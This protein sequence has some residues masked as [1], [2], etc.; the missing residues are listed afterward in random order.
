MATIKKTTKRTIKKAA[1]G[2]GPGDGFCGENWDR[3]TRR[4]RRRDR[5]IAGER[6]D[7]KLMRGVGLATQEGQEARQTARWDRKDTRKDNREYRRQNTPDWNMGG[8]RGAWKKG[9]KMAKKS[10]MAKLKMKKGGKVKKAQNG[11]L[12]TEFN[13]SPANPKLGKRTYEMDTTGYLAGAKRFP[14]KETGEGIT[15]KFATTRKGAKSMIERTQGSSKLNLP[16]RRASSVKQQK[17]G[18]KTSKRK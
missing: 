9:G 16:I 6:L 12:K 8:P 18:G 14:V 15:R 4:E 5:S 13:V 3:Q 2:C 1:S 10:A 7:Q 17:K 11:T